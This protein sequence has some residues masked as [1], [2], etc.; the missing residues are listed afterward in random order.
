MR[1][2]KTMLTVVVVLSVVGGTLAFKAKK[3][4]FAVCVYTSLHPG[5]FTGPVVVWLDGALTEQG[6]SKYLTTASTSVSFVN[7]QITRTC[8]S[9]ELECYSKF[10]YEEEF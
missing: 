9:P 1:K 5:I 4:F 3:K 7:G 8:L 2:V 10:T 6:A